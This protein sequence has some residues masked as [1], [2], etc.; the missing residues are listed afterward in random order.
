MYIPASEAVYVYAIKNKLMSS[1]KIGSGVGRRGVDTRL[2]QKGKLSVHT[3]SIVKGAS[4][5]FEGG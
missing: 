3:G 5:N 1:K 2:Y 4:V